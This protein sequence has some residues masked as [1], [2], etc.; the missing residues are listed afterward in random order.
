MSRGHADV[1]AEN[2]TSLI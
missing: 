1:L 2:F